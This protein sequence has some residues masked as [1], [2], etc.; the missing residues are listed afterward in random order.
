MQFIPQKNWESFSTVFEVEIIDEKVKAVEGW[1]LKEDRLQMDLAVVT[2]VV[3]CVNIDVTT[4]I[5]AKIVLEILQ[6]KVVEID[7]E[8]ME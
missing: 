8:L 1:G 4:F 3:A 2:N 7:T 5:G 6:K